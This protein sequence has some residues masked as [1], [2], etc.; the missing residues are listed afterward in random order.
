MSLN[1]FSKWM[2]YD[3]CSKQRFKSPRPL[4]VHL[5]KDRNKRLK[6]IPVDPVKSSF[7]RSYMSVHQ[8]GWLYDTNPVWVQ[9]MDLNIIQHSAR[10][11][12]WCADEMGQVAEDKDIDIIYNEYDAQIT[13][14]VDGVEVKPGTRVLVDKY[15]SGAVTWSGSR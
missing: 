4:N 2:L 9:G 11:A 13:M 3:I 14:Y 8:S 6:E 15:N 1:K 5:S 12:Y 10:Y 7:T